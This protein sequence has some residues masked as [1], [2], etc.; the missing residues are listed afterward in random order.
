MA[1]L[2]LAIE[3]PTVVGLYPFV[4]HRES[5]APLAP[6]RDCI[7]IIPATVPQIVPGP[8]FLYLAL[9]EIRLY[10]SLLPIEC[11]HELPLPQFLY[12][13]W[14][15]ADAGGAKHH[16]R[17]CGSV[18]RSIAGGRPDLALLQPHPGAGYS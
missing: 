6:Q 10:K 18:R 16:H 4:D 2:L 13:I 1:V 11:A 9:P 7:R 15:S 8:N 17:L 12:F 14:W 3:C 5:E